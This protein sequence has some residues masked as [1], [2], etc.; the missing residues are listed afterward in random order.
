MLAQNRSKKLYFSIKTQKFHC[1]KALF[2]ALPGIETALG[3]T[4][5]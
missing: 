3:A 5:K 4:K 2:P 1:E